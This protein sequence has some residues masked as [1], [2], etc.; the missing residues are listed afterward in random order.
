MT[1]DK[2]YEARQFETWGPKVRW[3][4]NPPD[5]GVDGKTVYQLYAFNDDN[6]IHLETFTESGAWRLINDRGIEIVAGA[7]GSDG[8]VDI[9][10]TGT[11]GDINITAMQ[12]GMVKIKGKNIMVEALEDVDLKAGRNINLTAG[13]GRIVLKANKI[14]RD[15]FSGNLAGELSF[16]ARAYAPTPLG[17]D[18]ITESFGGGNFISQIINS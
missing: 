7:K 15:T 14:D 4:V 11:N 9:C 16:A 13:S 5:G 8:K 6:D 12:N 17:V 1:Q 10:I 3:D 2:N 18:F